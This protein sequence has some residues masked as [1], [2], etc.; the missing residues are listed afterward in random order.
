MVLTSL[1]LAVLQA[2]SPAGDG[3]AAMV[4]LGAGLAVAEAAG[5]AVLVAPELFLPGYNVPD[6][7][8][9]AQPQGGAW[10]QDLQAMCAAAGWSRAMPNGRRMA[11][12]TPPWRSA[13]MGGCSR[14]TARFS[15]TA[16]AR[17][18]SSA[19]AS[20]SRPSCWPGG[21]RR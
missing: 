5:A 20:G 17:R 19:P 9:R 6:L 13:R 7:P 15:C 11:S 14:M 2:L 16:R 12:A 10:M 1:R 8:A 4:A 21:G 18:R 3:A